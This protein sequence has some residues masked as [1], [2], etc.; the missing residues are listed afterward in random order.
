MNEPLVP[1]PSPANVPAPASSSRPHAPIFDGAVSTPKEFRNRIAEAITAWL[2]RSPSVATHT[3]FSLD[4]RQ[5]LAF[6]NIPADA[7]EGLTR[8][9]PHHV[10]AWR[11]A[12]RERGLANASIRRKMTALRSLYAYLQRYGYCGGNPA[13]GDFVDAPTVPRDGKTV[14]LDPKDCRRLLDAPNAETPVGLRDRA[15]FALLAF[16]GCRV[17]EL[18]RLRVKDYKQS[19][20]HRVVEIQGKGG[21]ERR[22]PLHPEAIEALDLWL[23][24]DWRSSADQSRSENSSFRNDPNAPLFRPTLTA[25]GLGF[26]GFRS[27]PMTRR[28]VQYLLD[29]YARAIDLDPA[30]SV[31]SF[32]VTAL[33]TARERGC[34]IIDLQDFAGHSDPRTTLAYIRH[35]DRLNRSPAY[36]LGY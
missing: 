4:L 35:R 32:R 5:F 22:V 11:D 7:P 10:A 15:L 36:V 12:L 14:A 24:R 30:V 9:L 29:R 27:Q 20:S 21:K 23:A 28:A 26:D 3:N 17:G 33:T 31:H 25:R 2:L 8:I 1:Q 18:V 19:G 6:T 13:H 34:D 16:T